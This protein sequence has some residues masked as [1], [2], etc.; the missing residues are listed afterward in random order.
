MAWRNR[1]P[2]SCAS[3][4]SSGLALRW[5][6]YTAV[7]QRSWRVLWRNLSIALVV[8][9]RT[10]SP[11][12]FPHALTPG[13]FQRPEECLLETVGGI[14]VVAEQPVCGLPYERPIPFDNGL[15]VVWFQE[16]PHLVA[17]T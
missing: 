8:A 4:W 12:R 10:S 11:G 3:T 6:S 7:S 15:P 2:K 9:S 13:K 14:C 5:Q 1:P 17:V 16:R